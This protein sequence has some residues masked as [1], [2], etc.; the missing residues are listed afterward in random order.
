[1]NLKNTLQKYT[2]LS[3][4]HKISDINFNYLL[5]AKLSICN[6]YKDLIIT[7]SWLKII[8]IGYAKPI[9]K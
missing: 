9:P 5:P 1:M 6:F 4:Y 8:Y 2:S 3:L 7:K